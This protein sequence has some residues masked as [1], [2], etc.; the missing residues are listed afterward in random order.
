MELTQA[1]KHKNRTK[2][3]LISVWT[4]SRQ[5]LLGFI[6]S[7]ATVFESLVRF[8]TPFGGNWLLS[9]DRYGK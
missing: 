9:A 6:N 8:T 1:Y 5:Y 7:N 2:A 3:T 4:F